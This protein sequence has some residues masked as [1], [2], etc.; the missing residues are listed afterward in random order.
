MARPSNTEQRR[1][2]IA[3]GLLKVLAK[4]GYQGAAIADIAKA[5]R[6]T[7]GLV[8]Y[9]FRNK[10]EILLESAKVLAEEHAAR[11][12]RLLV[13]AGP[14]PATQLELFVEFHLSEGQEQDP[15]RVAAWIEVCAEALRDPKLKAAL[16]KW[17]K[18]LQKML[19]EILGASGP[20]G[21]PLHPDPPAAAAA[22]LA[23]IQGYY[24]LAT[25]ARPVVPRGSAARTA[26]ALLGV[27]IDPERPVRRG[28][29]A[30]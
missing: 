18:V 7:P 24:L 6:L 2:Q 8:H 13:L 15:E 14:D 30:R 12:E 27:W 1:R 19:V 26:R 3:E 4:K 22:V 5:A 29:R 16:L 17:W 9:H 25:T 21:A 28:R 10:H 11:L 20:Q 23:L